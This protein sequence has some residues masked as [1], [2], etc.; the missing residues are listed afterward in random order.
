M[1]DASS[2][3]SFVAALGA[4]AWFAACGGAAERG[5]GS[6]GTGSGGAIAALGG[7]SVGGTAGAATCEGPYLA[8]GCGCCGDIVQDVPTSCYYPEY[9]DGLAEIAMR[10]AATKSMAACAHAG[11]SAGTLFACCLSA[12][13]EAP[14]SAQYT[15]SYSG[16]DSMIV[17][18]SKTDAN[19]NCGTFSLSPAG[20]TTLPSLSAPHWPWWR[21]GRFAPCTENA[22][23]S[24]PIGISGAVAHYVSGSRCLFDVHVTLFFGLPGSSVRPVRFDVDGLDVGVPSSE[25][26]E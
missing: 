19:G 26:W 7:Q 17:R 4:L 6:G 13:A 14:G 16:P 3:R 11:C 18:I 9:G 20:G 8:C 5:D 1:R 23:G 12:P 22:Q 25:C 2:I 15:G 10:D 24:R 21:D